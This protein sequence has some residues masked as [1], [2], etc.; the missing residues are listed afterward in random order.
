MMKPLKQLGMYSLIASTIIFN[1]ACK[2]KDNETPPAPVTTDITASGEF[3]EEAFP[4]R[5]GKQVTGYIGENEVVATEI[6]GHYIFEG[7]ILVSPEPFVES[8]NGRVTGVGR[9]SSRWPNG[10]MPYVIGSSISAAKKQRIMDAIAHWQAKTSIRFVQRT[11]QKDYAEFVNSSG[12]SSYIGMTGGRQT[13]NIGDGCTTGNII[14]EIG[15][16]LGLY[17][18]Q[19]RIDR[20][21]HVIIHWDN[22]QSGHSHNFNK[23]SSSSAFDNG[24]M[25]FGSIMMYGPYSWSKNNK[26]TITKRDGSTYSVQRNGLSAGDISIIGVMY[27][28]GTTTTNKLPEVKITSPASGASY[29]APAN[30]T[31]NVT[32]T[33]SDGSISKVEFYNGSQYLGQDLTSPYSFTL[34]N[35][36]AGT[37]SI[38]AKAT[39]NKGASKTSTAVS[40]TVKNQVINN[41]NAVL[42]VYQHCNYSTSGYAVGLE[43]G[44]YPK[45]YNFRGIQDNDISSLKIKPG[46]E[47]IV[48]Q[49]D[50][51]KGPSYTFTSDVSC[52]IDKNINDWIS[53]IKVRPISQPASPVIV[54]QHCDYKGYGVGLDVGDYPTLYNYKGIQD[55]DIS[56]LKVA[57][58]YEITVYK[59]DYY[60]GPSLTFRA[61]DPCLVDNN[62]NDWISSI[63]IRKIQ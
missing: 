2:K 8:E 37:Y 29:N 27:G 39:D 54:Y 5:T 22:I 23:A 26:P 57:K 38:T 17:H 33:D 4:G 34:S 6:D 28:G 55:N 10:V 41:P 61:D 20:D 47:V 7:D 59:Y 51:F 45:L 32:A 18:E 53:S 35:L 9:K 56:S 50:D 31:I 62:I 49:Y 46:Y 44:E 63:K 11:N 19:T 30:V 13:I 1:N 40:I 43:V 24:S 15:H 21:N 14:H 36:A 16:A 48:Y 25:D 58:G 52:L 12:C 60:Q 42:T 3:T